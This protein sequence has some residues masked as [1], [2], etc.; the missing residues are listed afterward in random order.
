MG[1]WHWRI[2]TSKTTGLPNQTEYE[3]AK[4]FVPS[5]IM[6]VSLQS[7]GIN[8]A[9][10]NGSCSA[11]E[12]EN[13]YKSEQS[14]TDLQRNEP[15]SKSIEGDGRPMGQIETIRTSRARQGSRV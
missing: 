6:S 13:L 8:I 4:S 15:F 12:I 1:T 7:F 5:T 3:G 11:A 9:Q 10:Y 2:T 14:S